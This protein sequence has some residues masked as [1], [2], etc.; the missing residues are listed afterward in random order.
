MNAP[1]RLK[2]SE[3]SERS[4]IDI[5]PIENIV[6]LT[7]NLHS[8]SRPSPIRRLLR[9]LVAFLSSPIGDQGGWE[10]GARGL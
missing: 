3:P 5:P 10:A 4:R 1:L 7:T 8:S 2:D 9:T 6:G